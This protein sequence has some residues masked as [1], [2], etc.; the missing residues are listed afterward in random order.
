MKEK[1]VAADRILATHRV[2]YKAHGCVPDLPSLPYYLRFLQCVCSNF[3]LCDSVDNHVDMLNLYILFFFT[4]F[5]SLV[6]S[7]TITAPV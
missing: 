5:S 7:D 1:A 2:I 6:I 3:V 4:I